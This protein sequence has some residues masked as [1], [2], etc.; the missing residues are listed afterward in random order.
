MAELDL[1]TIEA[2]IASMS[3]EDVKKQL[4]ELRTRQRVQQKKY[5]N[6]DAAKAYRAKKNAEVKAMVARAKALGIYDSILEKADELA[7][8]K[9]SAEEGVSV[10][11][12]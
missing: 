6:A 2:S 10:G 3:E 1:S 4:T 7:D 8:E 11:A 9:I 5:H 12:E